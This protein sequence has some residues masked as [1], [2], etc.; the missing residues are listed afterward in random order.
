MN[1]QYSLKPSSNGVMG[2][3]FTLVSAH[4]QAFPRTAYPVI[5][6]VAPLWTTFIP[7][8]SGSI[9]R[10]VTYD[11]VELSWVKQ[12]IVEQNANLTDY[13][14]TVAVVVTWHDFI[15]SDGGE[16]VSTAMHIL[17]C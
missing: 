4:P 6:V 2:F 15:I 14:P 16:P 13:Q 3:N 5:P 1:A 8:T 10:R 9:F 17:Y 12:M 7:Q 11:P